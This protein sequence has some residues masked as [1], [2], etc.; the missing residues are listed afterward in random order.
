[1]NKYILLIF[2]M[3]LFSSQSIA[4]CKYRDNT[5]TV[6]ITLNPRILSDPSLPVG[7][8]LHA[9]TVGISSMKT[10]FDCNTTSSEPDSYRVDIGALTQ[11][12]GVTGIHGEPVYNTGIDGIGFQISD[13]ITGAPGRPVVAKIGTNPLTIGTSGGVKQVTVWLVKTKPIIDTSKNTAPQFT[14]TYAAGRPSQVSALTSNTVVLRVGVNLGRINYRETSCNLTLRGGNPIKLSTI[15]ASD[16]RKLTSTAST[17]KGKDI[18]LDMSCPT[19]ALGLNY[20]YWFNPVSGSSATLDG[21]LPNALSLAAGG[22][23]DVGF[24]IRQGVTPVKF[25]DYDEYKINNTKET[26]EIKFNVDYYRLSSD[27]TQGNVSALVEVVL[28]ER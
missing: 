5:G 12:P 14:V 28:Q 17:G 27:I 9:Q 18:I 8:I 4:D 20:Y 13:G 3:L 24:I 7:S 16:L 15:K 23:K 11:A 25:Y 1:M 2:G 6:G 26:Q 19:A 22:A 10:I 21:V